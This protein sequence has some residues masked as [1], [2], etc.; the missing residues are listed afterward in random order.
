MRHPILAPLATAGALLLPAAAAPAASPETRL[1]AT[2]G[3][4]ATPALNGTLPIG[5]TTVANGRLR[6]A[7]TNG[8]EQW[9]LVLAGPDGTTPAVGTYADAQP[10]SAPVAGKPSIGLT[11]P[12]ACTPT[13][14]ASFAITDLRT[15]ATTIERLHATFTLTC[16]GD[17]DPQTGELRVLRRHT[18][19]PVAIARS[20]RRWEMAV[21][22]EGDTIVWRESN[23]RGTAPYATFRRVGAGAARPVRLPGSAFP[24]AFAAG[25]V[26]GDVGGPYARAARPAAWTVSGAGRRLPRGMAQTGWNMV[27][28]TDGRF[29]EY[30]H[31]VSGAPTGEV[32]LLDGRTGREA[33]LARGNPV[34][35]DVRYGRVT[36]DACD[37]AGNVCDVRIRPVAGGRTRV[38]RP[39]AARSYYYPASTPSGDTLVVEGSPIHCGVRTRLV[40][41]PAAGRVAGVVDFP[42]RTEVSHISVVAIGTLE[43]AVYTTH[44]CRNDRSVDADV[45][46]VDVDPAVLPPLA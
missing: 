5:A 24:Y 21:G 31:R 33:V 17:T 12:R 15:A 4:G 16:T 45:W 42:P 44:D 37:R 23:L 32:R 35:G 30:S 1:I 40:R 6:I 14:G 39:P 13:P 7:F 29:W 22:I 28:G 46:Q 38:V 34:L 36:W 18:P 8:A 19:K 10:L 11:G 25:L 20:P 43:R 3:P 2:A 27:G 41:I 26:V 9:T